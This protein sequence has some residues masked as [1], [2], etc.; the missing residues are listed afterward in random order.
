MGDLP[1][2]KALVQH[3]VIAGQDHSQIHP[4]LRKQSRI[5]NIEN[6]PCPTS[7]QLLPA[8]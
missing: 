5:M 7:V 2:C 3:F 6:E 8:S 4:S 1:C